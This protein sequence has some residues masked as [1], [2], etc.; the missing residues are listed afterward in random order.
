MASGISQNVI[1]FVQIFLF[2]SSREDENE[3]TEHNTSSALPLQMSAPWLGSLCIVFGVGGEKK[4]HVHIPV[5]FPKAT[6]PVSGLWT[7]GKRERGP[8]TPQG[9]LQLPLM[10][11]SDLWF[12]IHERERWSSNETNSPK[13]W[14]KATRHKKSKKNLKIFSVC[15]SV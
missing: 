6:F 2:S 4:S 3:T 9:S 13:T 5:K 8:G 11:V 15:S 14:G 10:M 1:K 7:G 12:H